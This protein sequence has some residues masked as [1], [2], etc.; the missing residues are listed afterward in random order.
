MLKVYWS[1]IP[2]GLEIDLPPKPARYLCFEIKVWVLDIKFCLDF[3][4]LYA[5]VTDTAQKTAAFH[6]N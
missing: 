2:K 1:D 5:R 3:G 6:N 4:G